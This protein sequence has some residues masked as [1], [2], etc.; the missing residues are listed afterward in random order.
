MTDYPIINSYGKRIPFYTKAEPI[1]KEEPE[2]LEEEGPVNPS[3][4][5][6]EVAQ[7]KK[8]KI[9]SVRLPLEDYRRLLVMS[10]WLNI[11][12]IIKEGLVLWEQKKVLEN[13]QTRNND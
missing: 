4:P 6:A 7:E 5:S 1:K 8:D 2:V 10:R 13:S 9:I 12:G 11:S 3:A